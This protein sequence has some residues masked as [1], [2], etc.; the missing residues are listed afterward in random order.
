M[1]SSK[2]A[3]RNLNIAG[4]KPDSRS[5]RTR[6]FMLGLYYS[7]VPTMTMHITLLNGGPMF[8]LPF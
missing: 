4:D 8:L 7:S 3:P 5:P 2:R 1:T 6:S